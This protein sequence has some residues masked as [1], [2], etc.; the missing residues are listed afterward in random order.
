LAQ[1]VL[2]AVL[3]FADPEGRPDLRRSGHAAKSWMSDLLDEVG[4]KAPPMS[5]MEVRERV[6]KERKSFAQSIR[7]AF[8]PVR[9]SYIC[10]LDDRS[11]ELAARFPGLSSA[12]EVFAYYKII[13]R[14]QST[15]RAENYSR[16][17]ALQT[18]GAVLDGTASG[19]AVVPSSRAAEVVQSVH[20]IV[21]ALAPASLQG[22]DPAVLAQLRQE[23][24]ET[25]AALL[26][27][28]ESLS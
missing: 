2:E 14:A 13:P 25:R 15:I 19:D 12:A 26:A 28:E 21:A 7:E 6:A 11:E 9:V 18:I 4:F 3:L 16:R 1:V 10:A 22:L 17:A 23:L 20:R 27:L 5:A 8:S 24:S